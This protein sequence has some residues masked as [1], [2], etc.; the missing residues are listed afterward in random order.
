MGGW[1]CGPDPISQPVGTGGGAQ[2]LGL[3]RD[4]R[5]LGHLCLQQAAA[6]VHQARSFCL[7][8][9]PRWGHGGHLVPLL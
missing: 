1:G 3:N 7:S 4:L 5:R 6:V 9:S 2:S 8:P